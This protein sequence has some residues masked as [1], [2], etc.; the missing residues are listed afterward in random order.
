MKADKARADAEETDAEAMRAA[1]KAKADRKK[2]HDCERMDGES[3]EDHEKRKADARKDATEEER[4]EIEKADKAKKDAAASKET[5]DADRGTDIVADAATVT[6]PRAEFEKMQR[7][8][9]ALAKPQSMEDR[10][11]IAKA[12]H[13][14]DHAYQMLGERAPQSIAG[15]TPIA[16]RR[17]L[18]NGLRPFTQSWKN[19]AFHDSQQSQDFTLVEKSIYDEAAA[20]AKNPPANTMTGIREIVTHPNG[21]TRTEFIG[22]ARAVWLP[23]THPTKFALTKINRPTGNVYA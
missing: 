7:T 1:E 15:E 3:D 20:Y 10:D 12:F 6:V 13:R 16:Y 11:E 22:D 14:A 18:A 17:R 19:Y 9:N 5:V 2:R 23:Y 8:V 21:K 4:A